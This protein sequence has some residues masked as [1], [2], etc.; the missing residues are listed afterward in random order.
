MYNASR[1]MV[2]W[3]MVHSAYWFN[4]RMVLNGMM[5]LFTLSLYCIISHLN[6]LDGSANILSID[7][8]LI[9]KASEVGKGF[10][11][12]GSARFSLDKTEQL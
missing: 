2:Q 11:D 5:T 1:L 8:Y 9:D 6:G 7:G 10:S 4:F 3:K 12:K